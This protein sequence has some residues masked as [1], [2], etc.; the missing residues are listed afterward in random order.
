M[1]HNKKR[2]TALL[3][4][5]LI[6]HISKCLVESREDEAK[7][8]VNMIKKYYA[9]NSVLHKELDLFNHI[10]KNTVKSRD[11]ASRLLSEVVSQAK[12]LDQRALD[13]CKGRLIKEINYSFDADQFY[14]HKIPNYVIYASAQTLLSD[15]KKINNIEKIKI[16]EKI[17]DFL[18]EDKSPAQSISQALKLDPKYNNAVYKIVIKKFDDKYSGKLNENQRKFLT[19]YAVS[20]ISENKIIFSNAANN[21]IA[22]I[23]DSLAMIT[24]PEIAKDKDLMGKIT[25]CRKALQSY[26]PK[27]LTEHQV[28]KLLQ[29]MSLSE[30]INKKD[31]AA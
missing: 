5:F 16:E 29:Y 19:K 31:E 11:Y 18:T 28:V 7:K 26:D 23:Q 8:A 25:E 21:E 20:L 9:K 6:R 12:G 27:S 1:R 14:S 24:D 2:N 10:F 3:Y 17:V 30:A 22:K 15:S 4:E 13:Q